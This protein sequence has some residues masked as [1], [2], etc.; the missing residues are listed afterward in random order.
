M[1]GSS[2]LHPLIPRPSHSDGY[3]W[4]GHPSNDGQKVRDE[5]KKVQGPGTSFI[6]GVSKPL[7]SASRR[8]ITPHVTSY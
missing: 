7:G 3:P 2:P 6:G 1:L 8:N 5:E 4:N